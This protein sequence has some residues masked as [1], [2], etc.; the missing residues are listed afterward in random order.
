M[1][2]MLHVATNRFDKSQIYATLFR[3]K[4]NPAVSMLLTKVVA[5]MSDPLLLYVI[6]PLL[7]LKYL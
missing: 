6:I 3:E 7:H 4:K 5:Y 2:F 1:T